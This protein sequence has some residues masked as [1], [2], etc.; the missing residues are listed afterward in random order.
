MNNNKLKA[1]P[2][3]N[4]TRYFGLGMFSLVIY[5]V[6]FNYLKTNYQLFN[7]MQINDVILYFSLI[8]A[9]SFFTIG[10]PVT[11][12][13]KKFLHTRRSAYFLGMMLYFL[14]MIADAYLSVLRGLSDSPSSL[15][16]ILSTIYILFGLFMATTG[17]PAMKNKHIKED[18]S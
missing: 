12:S 9:V 1:S 17:H 7:E 5:L 14:V 10:R 3:E 13:T 16:G 2:P 15:F 8:G 11:I 18:I 4:V 6:S